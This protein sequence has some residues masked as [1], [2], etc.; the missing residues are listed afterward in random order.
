MVLGIIS[1]Q[2]V[3]INTRANQEFVIIVDMKARKRSL[4]K[5]NNPALILEQGGKD[6]C[7]N[8]NMIF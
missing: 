2:E 8:F 3:L 1:E 6:K 4:K 5:K 7:L